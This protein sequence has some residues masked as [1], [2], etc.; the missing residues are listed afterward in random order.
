MC[1]SQGVFLKRIKAFI[2]VMCQVPGVGALH[3]LSHLKFMTPLVWIILPILQMRK[4]NKAHWG[5]VPYPSS[6]S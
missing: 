5:Y 3:T 2:S 1:L 6:Q 4:K